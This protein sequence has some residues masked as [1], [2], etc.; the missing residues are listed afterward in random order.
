MFL[1]H[2]YYGYKWARICVSVGSI[3]LACTLVV[4]VFMPKSAYFNYVMA[5]PTLLLGCTVIF[6][7]VT[8]LR[9]KTVE[10]FLELNRQT[11][12]PVVVRL[13]LGSRWLSIG[14]FV[15]GLARDFK[16]LLS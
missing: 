16:R 15:M 1:L 8:L 11:R 6:A 7:S 12:T 9:S 13:L 10:S 2:M 3:V 5:I 4:P 14:I